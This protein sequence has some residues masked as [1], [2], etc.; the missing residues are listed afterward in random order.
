MTIITSGVTPPVATTNYCKPGIVSKC[1]AFTE[2]RG[3]PIAGHY[4]I[5][6]Y[7][8]RASFEDRCMFLKADEFCD[9]LAAQCNS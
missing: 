3:K 8:N 7:G 9:C 4:R 1:G 5:C 6:K 2:K